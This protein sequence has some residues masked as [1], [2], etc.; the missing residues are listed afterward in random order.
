MKKLYSGERIEANE[1]IKI[2][3]QFTT[4]PC[5]MKGTVL[6][7]TK[8]AGIFHNEVRFSNGI[9]AVV[10]MESLKSLGIIEHE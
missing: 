4:I 9:V 3:L 8:R 6:N 7:W 10:K 1:E 2:P 5:G